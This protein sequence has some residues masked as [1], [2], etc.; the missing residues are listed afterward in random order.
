MFD[1][2]F[3][4]I[5]IAKVIIFNANLIQMIIGKFSYHVLS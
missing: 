2:D 5:F 3:I 1:K 4:F